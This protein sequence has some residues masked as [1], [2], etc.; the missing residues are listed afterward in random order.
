ME[1]LTLN[2]KVEQFINFWSE[3]K[4]VDRAGHMYEAYRSAVADLTAAKAETVGFLVPVKS[5]KSL[6][7]GFDPDRLEEVA[8]LHAGIE[9]LKGAITAIEADI[10]CFMNVTGRPTV[11][12]LATQVRTLDNRL[13]YSE[14][15]VREIVRA[16]TSLHPSLLPMEVT[17][18]PEV[19]EAHAAHDRLKIEIEKEKA[20]LQAKIAEATKIFAKYIK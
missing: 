13:Q 11:G 8:A 12:Q 6:I 2:E 3:S 5:G 18:L 1:M 14:N 19:T 20:A 16:Q 7:P 17:R 10:E 4:T 15:E 9:E